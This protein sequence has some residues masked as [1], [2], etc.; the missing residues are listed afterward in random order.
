M[1]VGIVSRADLVRA[2]NRS[3][4]ELE[5]ELRKEVLFGV[6]VLSPDAFNVTVKDG[7]VSIEET[8]RTA[9]DEESIT[10]YV[11]GV[12][13]VL[14]VTSEPGWPEGRSSGRLL[15]RAAR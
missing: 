10:R 12:P 7:V 11:R 4:V 1:C 14:D 3:D 15:L 13:G 8:V 6:L 2:F 9:A 5:H